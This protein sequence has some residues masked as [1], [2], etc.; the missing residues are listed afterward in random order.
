MQKALFYC[1]RTLLNTSSSKSFINHVPISQNTLPN[2]PTAPI[3]LSPN[4]QQANAVIICSVSQLTLKWCSSILHPWE[5]A[6]SNG[7]PNTWWDRKEE[8]LP[9]VLVTQI[10]IMPRLLQLRQLGM[11]TPDIPVTWLVTDHY[12]GNS[13][14]F[15]P[16][17]IHKR[18]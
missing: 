4:Q 11:D 10:V 15:V 9:L 1:W 7:F 5:T 8:V 6:R 17:T 13:V 12:H 2:S 16:L 3:S 18:F 14:Y